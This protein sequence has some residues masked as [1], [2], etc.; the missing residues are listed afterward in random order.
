MSLFVRTKQHLC[1]AM[2]LAL[3]TTA[4]SSTQTALVY[5]KAMLPNTA[6][7]EAAAPD[8]KAQNPEEDQFKIVLD[9]FTRSCNGG[10]GAACFHLSRLFEK[11]GTTVTADDARAVEF[12]KKA[13]DAQFVPAMGLLADRFARA[14]GVDWDEVRAVDLYVKSC[15]AGDAISCL[16]GGNLLDEGAA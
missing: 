14:R 16:H 13:C 1:S 12:L 3:V 2:F 9:Q 6:K 5:P 8:Q 10:D 11:G 4:C 15:D 7:T